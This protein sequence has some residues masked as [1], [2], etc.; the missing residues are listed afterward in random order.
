MPSWIEQ[1]LKGITKEAQSEQ[2][3]SQRSRRKDEQP[4][5]WIDRNQGLQAS[6]G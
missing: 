6:V 4:P 3:D 2:S 1:G 5:G